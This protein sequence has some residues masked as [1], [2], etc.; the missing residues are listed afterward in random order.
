MMGNR[1][2]KICLGFAIGLVLAGLS[3]E[4]CRAAEKT[5]FTT[6]DAMP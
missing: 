3:A 2:L 4:N 1:K 6:E 5:V